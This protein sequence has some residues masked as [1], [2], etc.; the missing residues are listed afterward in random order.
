MT[1]AD[2]NQTKPWPLAGYA[3]GHYWNKCHRCEQIFV[4]DKRAVHCLECAAS[5][6]NTRLALK[7]V[8]GGE[9]S[10]REALDDLFKD[11]LNEHGPSGY[12][13]DTPAKIH[14]GVVV[15]KLREDVLALLSSTPRNPSVEHPWTLRLAQINERTPIERQA[16]DLGAAIE[17]LGGHPL[18][19]DALNHAD[20]AMRTLGAWKDAGA[21]G[22]ASADAEIPEPSLHPLINRY[23][24]LK[25]AAN[26]YMNAVRDLGEIDS[27]TKQTYFEMS[28]S[29]SDECL[30]RWQQLNDLGRDLTA[31]VKDENP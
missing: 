10:L 30:W 16:A 21:P 5:L 6:V 31:A 22:A 4:G 25:D 29:K 1:S 15:R 14:L 8:M 23:E 24:R 11:A 26:A 18:L 27:V 3:P 7:P 17:H 2:D 9:G 19:T 12:G 20:R 28:P 13:R